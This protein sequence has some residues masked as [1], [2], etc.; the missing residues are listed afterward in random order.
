MIKNYNKCI[1]ITYNF[2]EMTLNDRLNIKI[3][4]AY[5]HRLCDD[6][7]SISLPQYCLLSKTLYITGHYACV[8][9]HYTIRNCQKCARVC[10]TIIY[11]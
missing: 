3:C 1:I 8:Y 6:C 5:F 7:F 10:I 2:I 9:V 11:Y 4:N